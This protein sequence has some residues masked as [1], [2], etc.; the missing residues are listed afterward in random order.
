MDNIHE[1]NS[2]ARL[3]E[4]AAGQGAVIDEQSVRRTIY[5]SPSGA[6]TQSGER[7]A[8]LQTITAAITRAVS[9]SNEGIG[10][11]IIIL[12]G[13]YGETLSFPPARE[14]ISAPIILRRSKQDR[15]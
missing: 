7:H 3:I 12:P 10:V 15:Q 13:T 5:V 1:H 14:G 4:P 9:L 2:D 8:P 11:R 6:D